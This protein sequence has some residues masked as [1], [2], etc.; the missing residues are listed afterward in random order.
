MQVDVPDDFQDVRKY[1]RRAPKIAPDA[2]DM[3]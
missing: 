2:D 3:P 1:L